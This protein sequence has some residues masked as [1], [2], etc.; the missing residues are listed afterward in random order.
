MPESLRTGAYRLEIIRGNT[1]FKRHQHLL[2]IKVNYQCR[3][4]DVEV[5]T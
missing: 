1:Q 4:V 5:D 3:G 2:A